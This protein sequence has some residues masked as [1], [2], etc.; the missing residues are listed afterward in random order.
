MELELTR[1]SEKGQVVIPAD[2]RKDLDLKIGS[3]VAVEKM[4]DFVILKK[5][6]IPDLMKEFKHLAKEGTAIAKKMRIKSE[7]DIFRIMKNEKKD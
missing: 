3:T 7:E 1:I 2:I 4:K 6:K 5:V